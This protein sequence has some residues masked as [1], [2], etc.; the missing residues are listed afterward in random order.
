[1]SIGNQLHVGEDQ[2]KTDK[3]VWHTDT[4]GKY[5]CGLWYHRTPEQL[6][7]ECMTTL[8]D[9]MINHPDKFCKC[10]TNIYK[11]DGLSGKVKTRR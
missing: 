7:N 6:F 11:E 8:R 9:L 2:T 1:M 4:D 5:W 3:A 10:S